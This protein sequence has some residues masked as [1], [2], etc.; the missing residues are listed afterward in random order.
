MEQ[1]EVEALEDALA[2]L[3]NEGCATAKRKAKPRRWSTVKIGRLFAP[4]L[5]IRVNAP[6]LFRHGRLEPRISRCACIF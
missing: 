4:K 5:L 2:G 6:A 1:E 3:E